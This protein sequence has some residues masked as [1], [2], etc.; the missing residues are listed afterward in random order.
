M[1]DDENQTSIAR[2]QNLSVLVTM[3]RPVVDITISVEDIPL[4]GQKIIAQS[5][6][7]QAGGVD[8]NFAASMAW[9][10]AAVTAVGSD[11]SGPLA[12]VDR[13]SLEQAGVKLKLDQSSSGP[14]TMCYVFVTSEGQ[15]AVVVSYP[16]D[17]D[18]VALGLASSLQAV[19]DRTW[20]L[21][22][23]GVLRQHH[24]GLLSLIRSK[25]GL[26]ATTLEDSDWPGDWLEEQAGEIDLVF[27]ADETFAAHSDVLRRWQK[28]HTWDLVVTEGARGSWML[29][30]RGDLWREPAATLDGPVVDT[31]GAGDAFASAFCAGRL[32]GLTGSSLLRLAGWYAGCKVQRAGPRSFPSV[33]DFISR[34]S[35][36]SEKCA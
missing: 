15:R 27:C 25:V 19:A 26:L 7:A 33:G 12:H 30:G 35:E 9:L 13:V 2:L 11:S 3:G 14:E 10:G 28:D 29:G 8:G 21:G 4:A 18:R 16:H 24:K 20:D 6:N 32:L 36:F 5:V 22:Y 34:I 17:P 31:T 1:A 23:L